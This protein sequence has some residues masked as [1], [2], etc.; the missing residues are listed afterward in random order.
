[1]EPP[2]NVAPCL[3]EGPELLSDQHVQGVKEVVGGGR[4]GEACFRVPVVLPWADAIFLRD[5]PA[6]SGRIPD[7]LNLWRVCNKKFGSS[8]IL[9]PLF[10]CSFRGA[11]GTG[12]TST[13]RTLLT[14]LRPL[15]G[16]QPW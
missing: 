6:S 7:N 16:S 2:P 14:T 8:S 15:C 13:M 1:M 4:W 3:G 11:C 9:L 10:S 5:G 12:W